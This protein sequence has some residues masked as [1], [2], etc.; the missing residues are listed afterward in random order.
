MLQLWCLA[1][2]LCA[3]PAPD[4][5]A[6]RGSMMAPAAVTVEQVRLHARSGENTLVVLADGDPAPI[7]E[8]VE[9]IRT[10]GRWLQERGYPRLALLSHSMGSWMANVYFEQTADS[11]FAAWLCMGLTGGFGGMRNVRVPVLDVYGENDLA[12]VLRADWRRRATL[13][14]IEGSKQVRVAGADHQYTGRE[15]ELAME[16]RDFLAGLK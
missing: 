3:H 8:A 1:A 10:A 6:I 11:P 12:Q 2:A 15:K 4:A 5:P 9:R 14:S 16:I 7:R 13:Q